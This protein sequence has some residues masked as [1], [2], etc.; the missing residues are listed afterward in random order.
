MLKD[1]IQDT[2]QSGNVLGGVFK[3]RVESRRGCGVV[4]Y[5]RPRTL[6][7]DIWHR[8]RLAG[9]WQEFGYSGTTRKDKQPEAY[10]R[11]H[12]ARWNR[13]HRAKRNRRRLREEIVASLTSFADWVRLSFCCISGLPYCV[14]AHAPGSHRVPRE[15][16]LKANWRA[17]STRSA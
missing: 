14:Q 13:A 9:T 5:D 2:H 7:C 12:S 6:L 17:T 1:T 11:L 3:S 8:A 10:E 4:A 15:C 16:R